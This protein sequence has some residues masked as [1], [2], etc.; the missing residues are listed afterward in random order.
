[1]QQLE[2]AFDIFKFLSQNDFAYV[3]QGSI[4]ESITDNILSLTETN[5]EKKE[6]SLVLK[7]R[8]YFIMVECLQNITRHQEN[9]KEENKNL[10][11][12]FSVF[13]QEDKYFM[14]SGNYVETSK[15]NALKSKLEAINKFEKEELTK[16]YKELLTEGYLSEKGGAGLGLVE[17]AR[18]S[19]NKLAFKFQ[20]TENNFHYFYLLTKVSAQESGKEESGE[21]ENPLDKMVFFHQFI[22]RKKIL[23]LY[24]GG[25]N[26]E[27]LI[28]F[29]NLLDQKI[30][31][32]IIIKQKVFSVMI[33]L[34]QN[35][36]N[37]GISPVESENGNP[38]IFYI[39]EDEKNYI[40]CSGNII[41]NEN[42]EMLKNLI[43]K[44][45]S[46]SKKELRKLHAGKLSH[47]HHENDGLG[48]IEIKMKYAQKINFSFNKMD[49]DNSFYSIE[50][51]IE[52]K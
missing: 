50:A 5:L 42:M 11:D 4:S 51:M 44:I 1:M 27:N 15:V 6:K 33:E 12:F 16:Y 41:G 23:F 10:L 48:L 38:G 45:N 40:V 37:H 25:V 34:L 39:A 9:L 22:H 8:V 18:K 17:M 28:M 30:V 47:L 14:I 21:L 52:K 36:A 20:P 26:Q 13:K 3:Y 32:D 7:K 43:E 35:I 31:E 19:G 29:L 46:C 2:S 49:G 24:H